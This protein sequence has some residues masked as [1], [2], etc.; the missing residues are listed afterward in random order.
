M[1]RRPRLLVLVLAVLPV[2]GCAAP[3]AL[4]TSDAGGLVDPQAERFPPMADAKVTACTGSA[5]TWTI[6]G[7]VRNPTGAVASY[8]ISLDL[9]DAKGRAV[10]SAEASTG[11]VK[12]GSMATWTATA[13][14][15]PA[16]AKTCSVASVLRVS[17]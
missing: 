6:S 17:P 4:A 10:N 13:T 16:S 5:G 2:A 12:N 11:R 1:A 9:V 15:A 14:G 7:S 8:T 3:A